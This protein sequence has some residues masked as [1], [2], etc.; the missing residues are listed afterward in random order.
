M[1]TGL[2][3]GQET[4]RGWNRETR[5]ARTLGVELNCAPHPTPVCLGEAG[6][7]RWSEPNWQCQRHAQ[8]HSWTMCSISLGMAR[9]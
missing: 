3:R 5:Q 1:Q 2:E 7:L 9:A 4:E 6:L 8:G